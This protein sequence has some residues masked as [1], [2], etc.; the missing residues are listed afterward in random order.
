[1]KDTNR[2]ETAFNFWNSKSPLLEYMLLN[3]DAA[4][5]DAAERPEILS[6]LPSFEDKNVLELGAGIGRFTSEFAKHANKVT[7]LDFCPHFIASNQEKN[8]HFPNIEYLCNDVMDADFRPE[9]FDL[10]FVS[11]LQMY[12]SEKE[13]KSLSQ[14]I[15]GWLK[16]QGAFFFKESCAPSTYFTKTEHYYAWHRSVND[17]DRFY[18]QKLKLLNHGSIK[19]YEDCQADPFKCF[20]LYQKT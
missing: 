12:L 10:I 19:A 14:K 6:Y 11:W 9:S 4:T 7:A 5:L 3:N 1:M 17:Y 18:D 15:V 20:W 16:P 8:R 13:V 2:V